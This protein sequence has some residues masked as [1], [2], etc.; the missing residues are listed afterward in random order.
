VSVADASLCAIPSA[1]PCFHH[2]GYLVHRETHTQKL[3]DSLGT[4]PG[5]TRN[6]GYDVAPPSF[7][8]F[9][10]QSPE[11]GANRADVWSSSVIN[12]PRGLEHV[13]ALRLKAANF[14]G[15]YRSDANGRGRMCA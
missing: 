9:Y 3:S 6:H 15:I 4:Y 7:L 1:L 11:T 12:K 2:S 5:E 13:D 10:P 8:N 14:S